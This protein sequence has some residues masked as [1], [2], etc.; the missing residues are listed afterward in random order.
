MAK[1]K[2]GLT[3]PQK[4]VIEELDSAMKNLFMVFVKV[5]EQNIPITDA[6]ELIGMQIPIFVKPAINQLSGK[7]KEMRKEELEETKA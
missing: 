6:L 7:L 1:E 2:P 4:E 3:K 5:D